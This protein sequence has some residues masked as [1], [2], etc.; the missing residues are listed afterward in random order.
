MT[1]DSLSPSAST[2]EPTPTPICLIGGSGFIG[3]RLAARFDARRQDFFILDK[4]LGAYAPSR[5]TVAD[6]T[7]Q[8]ALIASARQ[9]ETIVNLAAEHRD[10]VRPRALYDLVNVDGARNVCA[11]ADSIGATRIVFTS[12][13]AVYGFAPAG[14]SENGDIRP[15]NDYGRTKAAAEQIYRAWADKDPEHRSLVIVRPTV[16]F[17]ERNRGNVFNLLSTIAAGKFVMIGKGANH[18][19]MAYVENVAAFL[20]HCTCLGPGT[21]V[22]NY[23]DKPDFNMARLVSLVRTALGR[24]ANASITIPTPLGLA[25]GRLFDLAARVSGR[26]FPISYV[27]VL[28]FCSETSFASAAE[29]QGFKAPFSLEQGLSRTI[30]FEF[31]EDNSTEE[32]FVTE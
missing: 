2:Q 3:S 7:D 5:T 9:S 29:S 15:F 30:R 4:R 23:V 22:F 16:V 17:G 21:H 11:L 18:K 19:S 32:T 28:K 24:K 25:A 14:T 1:S 12:T 31:L 27:R 8:A 13:V 20:D 6:V 26:K 10:D